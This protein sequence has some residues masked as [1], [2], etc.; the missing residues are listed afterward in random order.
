MIKQFTQQSPQEAFLE[1]RELH[2]SAG[3]QEPFH[4]HEQGQLIYPVSG[5]AKIRSE[6][7]VWV[8]APGHA[9]WLPGR[10]PHGL[11]AIGNV[12][13]HNLYM[14]PTAS[15]AFSRHSRSLAITPLFQSLTAAGLEKTTDPQR[16][17]LLHDLLH[18]E[19]LRLQDIALCHITLPHDR[20]IRQLC[21]ALCSDLSQRETLAWWGKRVGA[22]ERT[23]A[24]LFREETQLSFT[25]WR[26][27]MHL[28]EAVCHLARGTTISNL[29]S[30]LGYASS[31]A[32]IAMFRKKLG[33]SPQR[34]IGRY[35]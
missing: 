32:F 5:V 31:S 24:R 7:N 10:L 28:V 17:Q 25:E 35:L 30:T 8:V 15:A 2:Y 16:S 18:N 14:T 33:V 21:D 12:V 29:S 4:A 20:R 22:S 27:Q 19:L 3:S 6:Q 13:T 34:Y 23:L 11:E 1:V 26:Q 9:L